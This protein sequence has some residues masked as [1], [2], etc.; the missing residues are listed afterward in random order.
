MAF[1]KSKA[2]PLMGKVNVAEY[3]DGDLDHVLQFEF[4]IGGKVYDVGSLVQFDLRLAALE[5]EPVHDLLQCPRSGTWLWQRRKDKIPLLEGKWIVPD[6]KP[7]MPAS[8]F[9]FCV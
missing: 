3:P 6:P 1:G 5:V 9:H 2:K 4:V 8:N 7:L